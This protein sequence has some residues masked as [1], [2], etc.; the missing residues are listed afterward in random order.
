[1]ESI[2][3]V[4][5]KRAEE[6]PP[7]HFRRLS[8]MVSEWMGFYL[9]HESMLESVIAARDAQQ[10]QHMFPDKC[11]L[12]AALINL[13]QVVEDKVSFWKDVYGFD[14]RACAAL[15]WQ[16]SIQ[17]DMVQQ[18]K[19]HQLRSEVAEVLEFNMMTV[20]KEEVA[21]VCE[22]VVL[23]SR[24]EG[25]FHGLCLWF[26]CD[27]PVIDGDGL[28]VDHITLNTSPHHPQTHWRQTV[29][30]F[31]P[32][33]GC[34][35]GADEAVRARIALQQSPSNPRH[36]EI[37]VELLDKSANDDEGDGDTIMA[38][39]E[40]NANIDG[41]REEMAADREVS[42][43]ASTHALQEHDEECDCIKCVVIRAYK[44]SF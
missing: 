25:L 27:F 36:Y 34:F 18:V 38:A 3:E 4:Q 2:I 8:L 20:K 42:S 30:T 16:E 5:H 1:M 28:V 12:Y 23:H 11:R 21:S 17:V 29:V 14:Y 26:E 15:S 37:G 33:D 44:A 31:P 35:I 43:S 19:A 10:P 39:D 40:G 13:D 7:N 6:L 32:I 9:L 41:K 22:D 24:G